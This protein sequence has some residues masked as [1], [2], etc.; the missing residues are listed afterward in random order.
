MV[1]LIKKCT[2]CGEVKYSKDFYKNTQGKGGLTSQCKSCINEYR[3]DYV[4]KNKDKL[5]SDRKARYVPKRDK[6]R[7]ALVDYTHER[8]KKEAYYYANRSE[9]MR[10]NYVLYRY[11]KREDL[12]DE[13]LPSVQ[14]KHNKYK[15]R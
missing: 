12:M 3:K 13:L 1:V 11:L 8:A 9:L 4:E 7:F 10:D 6:Y 15:N 2:K 14:G 5:I